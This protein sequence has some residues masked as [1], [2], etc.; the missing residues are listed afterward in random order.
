MEILW[1]NE[2]S[3]SMVI[4]DWCKSGFNWLS[5]SDDGV[6]TELLLLLGCLMCEISFV[7]GTR[8]SSGPI[9]FAFRVASIDCSLSSRNMTSQRTMHQFL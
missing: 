9:S 2:F 8:I 4:E 1:H 6:E 5:T 3:W 7:F